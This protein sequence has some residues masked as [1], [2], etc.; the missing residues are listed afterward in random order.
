MIQSESEKAPLKSQGTARPDRPKS[1]KHEQVILSHIDAKL[2]FLVKIFQDTSSPEPTTPNAGESVNSDK[3]SEDGAETET[4][5]KDSFE[6]KVFEKLNSIEE[7]MIARFEEVNEKISKIKISSVSSNS[8]LPSQN[9]PTQ[10]LEN[11]S[12]IP[13]VP[14]FGTDEKFDANVNNTN[15]SDKTP[16]NSSEQIQ[17][18]SKIDEK[19]TEKKKGKWF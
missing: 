18:S 8:K 15:S 4:E 2:D 5:T 1:D 7:S 19:S 12:D 14:T 11:S 10:T 16:E 3:K 6:D 13:P 9:S 17:E